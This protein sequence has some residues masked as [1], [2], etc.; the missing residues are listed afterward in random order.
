MNKIIKNIVLIS[1]HLLP[2]YCYA[3]KLPSAECNNL[4]QIAKSIMKARQNG[5]EMNKI[6]NDMQEFDSDPK[7]NSMV[8]EIV[9]DAYN[10]L[11]YSSKANKDRAIKQFGNK[12]Y[13][14]C[15]KAK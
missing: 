3:D 13:S 12:Y 9:R 7:V 1:L 11:L 4:S 14:D 5:I 8:E 15:L 2:I 6:M 10:V